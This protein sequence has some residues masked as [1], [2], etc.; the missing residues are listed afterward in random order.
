M[1][2]PRLSRERVV[3]AALAVIDEDGLEALTVR[4][5]AK[6]LD[7]QPGALYHHF[8]DMDEVKEE[9]VGEVVRKAVIPPPSE[10]ITWQMMAKVAMRSFWD[11]IL[12]H[13]NIIPLLVGAIGRRV[14]IRRLYVGFGP[15]IESFLE[16][17]EA[18]GIHGEGA[19][20]MLE[21]MEAFTLGAITAAARPAESL[22]AKAKVGDRLR[23]ILATVPS[24]PVT[25]FE[26]TLEVTL[27]ALAD[28]VRTPAGPAK[29][30]RQ[31]VR[32]A[33]T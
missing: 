24:D 4:N 25:R 33:R 29:R 7:V 16:L 12:D 28:R 17:L 5:I 3:T 19:L 20:M 15:D 2:T 8:T 30:P 27:A 21:T 18:D 1:A 14:W 31:R 22:G 32:A 9:V 23:R 10:D 26:T 6:R 11:A 13:P